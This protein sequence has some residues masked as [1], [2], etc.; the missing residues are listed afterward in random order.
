MSLYQLICHEKKLSTQLDYV[1]PLNIMPE[2]KQEQVLEENKFL[3]LIVNLI[4]F[5]GL[6][7]INCR[8]GRDNYGI[9]LH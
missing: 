8:P 1:V 4:V 7:N 9:C 2:T 3:L 6:I 5:A